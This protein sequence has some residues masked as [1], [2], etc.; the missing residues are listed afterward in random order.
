MNENDT[1]QENYE[2]LKYQILKRQNLAG[3]RHLDQLYAVAVSAAELRARVERLEEMLRHIS[4]I[5]G[6]LIPEPRIVF[7]PNPGEPEPQYLNLRSTG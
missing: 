4:E 5:S 2:F 1:V 6:D 7:N 3:A